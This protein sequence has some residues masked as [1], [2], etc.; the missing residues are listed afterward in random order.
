MPDLTQAI[1]ELLD[2]WC[3]AIEDGTAASRLPDLNYV[4]R[5][6]EPTWS[7][8]HLREVF[9]DIDAYTWG[10]H[11]WVQGHS[12]LTFD[13][14]PGYAGLEPPQ[15]LAL[16]QDLD[17]LLAEYGAEPEPEPEYNTQPNIL[18]RSDFTAD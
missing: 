4:R 12:G 10:Q 13:R 16:A 18:G 3:H 7:D 11:G 17:R 14:S 1:L 8:E 5:T 2:D 6:G 9:R 15:L